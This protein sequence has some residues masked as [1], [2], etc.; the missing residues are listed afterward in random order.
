VFHLDLVKIEKLENH[1]SPCDMMIDFDPKP[2]RSDSKLPKRDPK[3]MH[4]MPKCVGKPKNK[5]IPQCHDVLSIEGHL[6]V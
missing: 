3:S 5:G 2:M 4:P 6:R 1:I